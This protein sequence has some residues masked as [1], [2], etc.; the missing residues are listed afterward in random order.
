MTTE[1]KLISMLQP[2]DYVSKVKSYCNKCEYIIN[3]T[4]KEN[5]N[6]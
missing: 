5:E 3:K 4:N 6:I 2:K 1:E